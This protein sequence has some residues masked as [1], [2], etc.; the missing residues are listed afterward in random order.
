MAKR[1]RAWAKKTRETLVELLGGCCVA[2]GSRASLELDCLEPQGHY[3]HTLDM[4]RR[5]SFFRRQYQA[6]NLQVLCTVCHLHKSKSEQYWQ[7]SKLV[8]RYPF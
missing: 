3:H 4:S 7:E 5:A 6:N 2:C 8:N 1:Q